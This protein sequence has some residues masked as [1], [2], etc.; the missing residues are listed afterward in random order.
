MKAGGFLFVILLVTLSLVSV[1]LLFLASASDSMMFQANNTYLQA[2][3]RNLISS[4][5]NWAKINSQNAAVRDVNDTI[6]LDASK[7]G[8][9]RSSLEIK[10][11]KAKDGKPEVQIKTSCSKARMTLTNSS[12]FK[13]Q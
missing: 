5:L 10:F 7:M 2:C 6:K 8:I 4:G 12:T 11:V 3:E 13:I 9:M 1:V